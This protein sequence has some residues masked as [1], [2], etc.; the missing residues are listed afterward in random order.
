MTDE[1]RVTLFRTMNAYSGTYDFDGKMVTHH[2]DVSWNQIWTGTDQ[3]RSVQFEGRKVV[4]T[5][6]PATF[7]DGKMYVL[8][9]TWEKLD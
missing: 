1:E 5:T 8:V 3:V 9:L 2:I 6:M 4:L 7:S